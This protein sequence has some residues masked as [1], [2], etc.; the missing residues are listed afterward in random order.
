MSLAPLQTVNEK[1]LNNRSNL[2]HT[3]VKGANANNNAGVGIGVSAGLDGKENH[4]SGSHHH[5]Y[6]NNNNNKRVEPH[7]QPPQKKKKEKLSALC[8]TP[9]SLILL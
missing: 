2:V 6:Q 9:P 7:G 3:P 5:N 8:K 4:R 1:R